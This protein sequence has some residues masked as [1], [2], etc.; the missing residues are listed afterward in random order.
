MGKLI[1]L[2][3]F[4]ERLYIG[5][6]LQGTEIA[7]IYW[8]HGDTDTQGIWN[9]CMWG[10]VEGIWNGW[11]GTEKLRPEWQMVFCL[12][13]NSHH[14]ILATWNAGLRRILKLSRLKRERM[15]WLLMPTMAEGFAAAC[16]IMFLTSLFTG[17]S[18]HVEEGV[19][20]FCVTPESRSR[21]SDINVGNCT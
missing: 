14:M 7:L 18:S 1:I 16:V 8:D 13:S 12:S 9:H 3:H 20:L 21:T 4:L 10:M 5:Y 19:G 11:L 15:F 2:L 17:Q 6:Y